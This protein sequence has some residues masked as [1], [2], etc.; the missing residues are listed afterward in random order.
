MLG[1]AVSARSTLHVQSL[2]FAAV[3]PG[4]QQPSPLT[5][6]V[7]GVPVHLPPV[8]LGFAMHALEAVHGVPSATGVPPWQVP[9]VHASPVT[10]ELPELH[11]VP[12]C[13]CIGSHAKSAST[14]VFDMQV[15]VAGGHMR[16]VPWHIPFVHASFTV[17]NMPDEQKVPFG[18][19]VATQP[20]PG[21]Q[22]PVAHCVSRKVQFVIVSPTHDPLEQKPLE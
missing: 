1:D 21:W 16:G 20:I 6:A 8:Q 3:Q 7:M 5:Q 10:H 17:Q 22:V 14:H 13:A 12:S 2:S 15:P 19:G 4:G 18:S 11:A 9:A